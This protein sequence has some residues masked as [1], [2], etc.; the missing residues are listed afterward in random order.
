MET[1]GAMTRDE[2]LQILTNVVRDKKR[3]EHY[4]RTIKVAE[5]CYRLSTGDGLEKDLQRFQPRESDEM[6]EQRLRITKHIV[7]TIVKNLIDVQ[8][9][10]PRSNSI[11]RVLKYE[12][13][14]T[15]ARTQ[16]F[17]DILDGFWGTDSF[18]QWMETRM[19]ELNNVD[20]NAFMV[21]EFKD[22]DPDKEHLQPYP[23]EV[24]SKMA[25]MYEYDNKVLQYLA[26]QQEIEFKK[27]K[28]TTTGTKTTLYT[29]NQ[30][31]ILEQ[32]WDQAVWSNLV[33]DEWYKRG[34]II[35]I[36]FEDNMYFLTEPEPYDLEVIPAERIGYKRDLITNGETYVSPYWDTVPLLDKTIKANS[37][38]DL[39]MCLHAFPQKIITGMRCDNEQCLGGYVT[40]VDEKTGK[41]TRTICPRCQGI[42][43]LPHTSAQDVVIVHLPEAKE[44]QLS[45]DN[46]VRYIYPPI[47]LLNFQDEYIEK[48]TWRAKQTMFNSDI[49]TR[50]EVAETATGKNIDLQNVYDT[51]WPFAQRYAQLW[52]FY[53]KVI[54]ELTDMDEKLIYSF[55][56]D[57]DFKMKTTTELYGDLRTA[58]ESGADEH[59]LDEI[60][61]DIMRN[62]FAN[63]PD[64]F[65]RWVV[66]DSFKP[67][68]GK[69]NEQKMAIMASNNTTPFY[70]IL[71]E[72]Y[73]NIFNEIDIK[74]PDF[75]IKN[76][77][78]QWEILKQRVAKIQEDIKEPVTKGW[79]EQEGTAE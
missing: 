38:L 47:D 43:M 60:Q 3:H 1:K 41:E 16:E 64:D 44:E 39:A 31:Y 72:N 8:Y 20:P 76:R 63:S 56:F 6:F 13:D 46:I 29:T 51:L 18:D 42:G 77:D 65:R 40:Y 66:M 26:V 27:G 71:Y 75:Y 78:K 54:S 4:E 79:N 24:T 19:V 2:A 55:H 59:A 34:G 22:F 17:E 50:E 57:K 7:P 28:E 15:S 48:L 9:K 45:L 32:T 68:K 70:K 62:I 36:R 12:N 49:F 69:T 33:K 10:V 25:V 11:T 23:F 52:E 5:K 58:A 35:Y 74:E 37:E 53:V 73:E 14:N 30:A 61:A 21:V 67:F